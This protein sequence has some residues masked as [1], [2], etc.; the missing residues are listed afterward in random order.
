MSAKAALATPLTRI[1]IPARM[2]RRASTKATPVKNVA[3][4]GLGAMGL[5]MLDNFIAA[6]YKMRV[7]DVNAS[8]M[9]EASAKGADGAASPAEAAAGVDAVVTMVPNDSI[10]RNVTCAPE[11]G[12]LHAMPTS[13]ANRRWRRT[14]H[15]SDYQSIGTA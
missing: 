3:L 12:I 9:K 15:L 14:R 2:T 5:P 1:A 7:Y 10:L 4:I 11:T 8:A 6:G 13:A